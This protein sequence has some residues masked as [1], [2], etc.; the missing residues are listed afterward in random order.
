M[1]ALALLLVL[2]AGGCGD[3]A[4][5][6]DPATGPAAAPA[7]AVPPTTG[8]ARM[9]ALLAEIRA[10]SVEENEYVGEG[11][12]RGLLRDLAAL[13]ADAS[14]AR[15]FQALAPL[16]EAE[17]LLGREREGLEHFR[18]AYALLPA[19]RGELP[20]GWRP[21]FLYRYGAAW[22]RLGETENCCARNSPESCIL[23]LR[24]AALHTRREGS[25][26]ALPL[27]RELLESTHASSPTYLQA[28]WLYNV[29]CMTLGEYPDGVPEPWR[30]PPSAFAP[31]PG[32]ESFPRFP[33]VAGKL[34]L[35][36]FGLSGGAVADDLDGDG[37][38]DLMVSDYDTAGPL[39]LFRNEG[40][41]TFVECS[42][43]AGLEG[44]LGGLNMVQGDYDGDGRVDVLV[45]RGAWNAASGMHP[46]SLLR[47]DGDLRFT[48]RTFEA[49]LGKVHLPTQTA[50]WADYDND[51]DLDLYVGN[52]TAR[53]LDAPCSL[54]RNQG[55]G[56]FVDV[57]GPAGVLNGGFTKGVAWGDYDG[58]RF[59]DLY[60]SNLGGANRLYRNRGDGTFEDVAPRLG[61]TGPDRSFPCWF[62]DFDDDGVLDLFVSGF[63]ASPADLAAHALGKPCAAP[64]P[65]L[66]RGDGNGGFRDVAAAAGLARPSSP[67]GSNFGDL[68][69]DGRLDFYLGTGN[70]G[71]RDIMPNLMF[72]NRDGRTFADVTLPGG[73]G[74]LQKGHAVAF[75]DFDHDGDLDVFEEMGGAYAGDRFHDVLYENPGFG[76]RWLAVRLEG[77]RSNRSAIGARLRATFTEGGAPRTIHRT[78][79]SGGSFGC[80]PL[81]QH[82]GLGKAAQVD[83]LEVYWPATGL[84]QTFRD[85]PAERLVEIVEGE[86]TPRIRTLAPVRLGGGA[87]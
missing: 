23:P 37:D 14:A 31:T 86:E 16:A 2:G 30:I 48:D 40:D 55:D 12:V 46:N 68:D 19:A 33:N 5:T 84:T 27:F 54:F 45:L 7:P 72:R 82:L 62:W 70:T 26:N 10:R 59:P 36:T 15:R 69:N 21:E 74:H 1:A 34:G 56:T 28:L 39:R 65:R 35:D 41:G 80:N 17:V 79:G 8:H 44:I 77:R 29:A 49:G 81:R 20:G 87:R 67:M 4:P 50:G 58:D 78:V 64:V 60:V 9:V 53:G 57:A 3:G 51:G 11:R 75:A 42:R 76:N 25:E 66:Y 13:P 32:E 22:M 47:N 43:E 6:A 24:G 18:E 71:M 63:P 85:L 52:E 61:V 83:R 73:F 38:I